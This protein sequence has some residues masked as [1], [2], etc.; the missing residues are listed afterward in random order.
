MNPRQLLKRYFAARPDLKEHRLIPWLGAYA[1][2]PELWHF[3]R[4][5]VAGGLAVGTF[6]A[7]IPIPAQMLLAAAGAIVFRVNLPVAV[8]ATWLTNPLPAA[9]AFW[10]AYKVGALLTG[11]PLTL[12]ALD[13]ER[14]IDGLSHF[15]SETWGPALIG[16]VVCGAMLAVIA[17]FA[18]RWLWRLALLYRRRIRR[19]IPPGD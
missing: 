5:S 17:N 13:F 15:I 12:H 1:R 16:S 14:S 3:G 10:I 4:R 6:F 18:V 9:P 8:A 2:Y 19:Q 7:F 11:K